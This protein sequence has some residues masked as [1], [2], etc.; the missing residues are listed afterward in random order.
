MLF[1]S[2]ARGGRR[3][4]RAGPGAVPCLS[5]SCF[6]RG[7]LAPWVSIL[8]PDPGA[9]SYSGAAPPTAVP[10]AQLGHTVAPTLLAEAS[11]LAKPQIKEGGR[12]LGPQ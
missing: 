1:M 6:G 5:S 11:H 4:G 7:G 8:G 12:S 10:E 2:V 9:C 3:G